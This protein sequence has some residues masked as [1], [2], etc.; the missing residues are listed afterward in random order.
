MNYKRKILTL[1]G[2]E[3]PK[4][5]PTNKEIERLPKKRR[6]P[7]DP[8]SFLEPDLDK[9]EKET[10][11]NVILNCLAVHRCADRKEGFYVNLIAQ[12]VLAGGEKVEL[13]EKL[14]EFLID[15]LDDSIMRIEEKKDEKGNVISKEEKGIY[16]GW[17]ICQVFEELGIK[18]EDLDK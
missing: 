7:D 2:E 11:G 15:I 18:P 8:K 16:A 3:Y 12:S 9:L 17:V 14:K 6:N 4:S 1:R 10:V 13:K 5:F